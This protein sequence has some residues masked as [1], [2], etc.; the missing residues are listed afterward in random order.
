MTSGRVYVSEQDERD[1][2]RQV[3]AELRRMMEHQWNTPRVANARRIARWT[4]PRRLGSKWG[5]QIDLYGE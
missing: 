5:Y 3:A 1:R 2:Q 4:P